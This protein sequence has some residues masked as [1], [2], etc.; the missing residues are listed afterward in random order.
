MSTE[1]MPA[2]T[3][4]LFLGS[5][6]EILGKR[7]EASPYYDE[8]AKLGKDDAGG[9]AV[10]G[11]DADDLRVGAD[12]R[13]LDAGGVGQRIGD[14]AHAAAD[15]APNTSDAVALAHDVVE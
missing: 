6:Y 10:A 15:V 9:P 12:F 14:S 3:K 4:A 2:V 7:E 13:S 8:A 5:V 11:Q 1:S